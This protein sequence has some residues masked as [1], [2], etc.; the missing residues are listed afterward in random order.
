MGNPLARLRNSEEE[1]LQVKAGEKSRRNCGR[2]ESTRKQIRA[3][4]EKP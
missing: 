3:S 4:P 2:I 1:N